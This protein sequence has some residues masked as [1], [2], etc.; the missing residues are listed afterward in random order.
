MSPDLK[1]PLE[2]LNGRLEPPQVRFSRIAYTSAMVNPNLT[3]LG[4]YRPI[5][6]VETW[7]TVASN[8]R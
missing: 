7:Q 6:S 5:I 3:V 4:V 1:C 2:K 8:R